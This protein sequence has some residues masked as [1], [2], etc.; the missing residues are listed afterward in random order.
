VFDPWKIHDGLERGGTLES[1]F[2]VSY[3]SQLQY[4]AMDYHID[5][6]FSVLLYTPYAAFADIIT[7][8]WTNEPLR[9][10]AERVPVLLGLHQGVELAKLVGKLHEGAAL[11]DVLHDGSSLDL[12]RVVLELVGQVV[13]VLWL[14]VHTSTEKFYSGGYKPIYSGVFRNRQC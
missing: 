11:Q 1:G 6:P 14:A 3:S 10:R 12:S 13:G 7:E 8:Y 2:F 4:L 9:R 5:K